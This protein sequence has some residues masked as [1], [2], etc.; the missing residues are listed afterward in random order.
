MRDDDKQP[1]DW[2]GWI[3]LVASMALVVDVV[4]LILVEANLV[5]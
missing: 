2:L 3:C 4:H 1:I 5:R